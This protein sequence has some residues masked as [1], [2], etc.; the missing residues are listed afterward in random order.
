MQKKIKILCN[1]LIKWDV[2]YNKLLS[3]ILK[4]KGKRLYVMKKIL[5]NS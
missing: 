1:K 4:I 2:T 3:S 5:D